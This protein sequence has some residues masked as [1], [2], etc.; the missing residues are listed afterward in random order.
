MR[1]IP[2]Q[3]AAN[4]RASFFYSALL[5]LLL[6][7]LGA[8][9]VGAYDPK[10]VWL[11]AAGAGVAGIIAAV[12]ARYAGPQIVLGVSHARMATDL[13]RQTVENVAHEMAIASGMPMPQVY[14]IDDSAP[15]A[16]ATGKDPQHGIICVSTGLLRMLNRDELQGVVAHEMAHIRNYDIR[17]MTT[18]AMVAGI[19]PMIS[20]MFWNSMRF[21][22]MR[23]SRSNDDNDS[24]SGQLQVV[25]FVLALVLAILAPIFSTLIQ[26]A[27]SRKREFLADSTAALLTR[28]PEGLAS[29][30]Q[31]LEANTERLEA[32]NH[33]TAHMFIVN[34]FKGQK[35]Q[36]M[37]SNLTSTHPPTS[38]RIKAL[39]GTY[40]VNSTLPE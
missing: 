26:L 4:K 1:S 20:D 37:M 31:K 17:L 29:A 10:S 23:R 22:G 15:N 38:E 8:A 5:V 19:I 30:L 36:N 2:Q 27:V 25:F 28:N 24:S 14:I 18:L 35:V 3:I 39:L 13:E 12:V 21:G 16:F 32:A 11:G 6:I 34:P 7:A 9:V 40:G 33:A